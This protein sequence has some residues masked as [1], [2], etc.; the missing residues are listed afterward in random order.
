MR[1]ANGGRLFSADGLWDHQYSP[2]DVVLLDGNYAH[3]VTT[4]KCLPGQGDV[5][6]RTELE[7]FSV[8]VFN[9]FMREKM[10][11]GHNYDAMWKP[12]WRQFV[13]WRAGCEPVKPSRATKRGRIA[14]SDDFSWL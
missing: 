10:K 8:I 6:G 5:K 11:S 12:N 3:G 2:Q 14:R 13:P 9:K 1:I 4:L 7:R